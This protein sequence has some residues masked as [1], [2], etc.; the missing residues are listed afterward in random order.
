MNRRYFH[1]SIK[2]LESLFKN[3]QD[4]QALLRELNEELTHRKTDRAAKLRLRINARLLGTRAGTTPPPTQPSI[5]F[6][7]IVNVTKPITAKVSVAETEHASTRRDA[8]TSATHCAFMLYRGPAFGR[9]YLEH[10]PQENGMSST[11]HY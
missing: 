4:D 2:E 7:G 6:T 3:G 10:M 8:P 9:D 11:Q 5:D 1:S